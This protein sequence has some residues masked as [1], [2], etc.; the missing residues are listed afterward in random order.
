MTRFDNDK[1]PKLSLIKGGPEKPS[2][3][4]SSLENLSREQRELV[5][6]LLRKASINGVLTGVLAGD[7]IWDLRPLVL[8]NGTVGIIRFS[9]PGL[10]VEAN[11][12]DE[13]RLA[14]Q[15]LTDHRFFDAW[16]EIDG[17]IWVRRSFM[18]NTGNEEPLITAARSP[19]EAIQLLLQ[20]LYTMHAH[21]NIHGH[22]T[23]SN[24]GVEGAR[25]VLLDPALMSYSLSSK[26]QIQDAAP[27]IHRGY[28]PTFAS[29]LYG[30]GLVLKQILSQSA[31]SLD[32]R[33]CLESLLSP[34]PS[35]RPSLSW[36]EKSFIGEP[37]QE[38]VTPQQKDV[39]EEQTVSSSTLPRSVFSKPSVMLSLG[40]LI[41]II[42]GIVFFLG[43][44]FSINFSKPALP[45]DTYWSSNQLARMKEVAERAVSQNDK[46]AQ[47]VIIESLGKET[48]P[49]Y[50]LSPVLK[51]SFDP[52]W[53]TELSNKDRE[54]A[55]RIALAPLLPPALRQGTIPSSLHPGIVLG[56]VGTS[57]LTTHGEQFKNVATNDLGQ[58][59][60][61]IG[62]LFESLSKIGTHN[63]EELASRGAAHIVLGDI[64]EK[65][66]AAYLASEDGS[67]ELARTKLLIPF[68][69]D[70]ATAS[71]TV[72]LTLIASP[73]GAG[74]I[75][76]WFEQNPLD[77]W[78]KVSPL[79]KILVIV[80]ED[81]PE[82]LSVEQC[83][84]LFYFPLPDTHSKALSCVQK[85]ETLRMY[86]AALAKHA[87][88]MTRIQTVSLVSALKSPA[89]ASRSFIAKWFE[90]KPSVALVIDLL[91]AQSNKGVSDMLSLEAARYLTTQLDH[92]TLT[93]DQIRSL[94]VHPEPLVRA[95]GYLKLNV[96]IPGEKEILKS[97]SKIEP[98]ERMR[99][100]LERRL[101][102]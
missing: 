62:Y 13:F 102:Q 50:I 3:A 58:L 76:Q 70:N 67:V 81:L 101:S 8:H 77:I 55:F 32:Q 93:R 63:M 92:L 52:R 64:G 22:I 42:L 73:S 18:Q 98:D 46:E 2:K 11:R 12:F 83:V 95:L 87:S 74:K 53:E 25:M 45:Y 97:M 34:D 49:P 94:T 51:H 68:I 71:S 60:G 85:D 27:E 16:G 78:K 47:A 69:K 31:M 17:R 80:D 84:D 4:V 72:F 23:L 36:V 91:A 21:G 54:F 99:K 88:G 6:D 82:G 19:R 15:R 5:R 96:R 66:I 24:I 30:L 56:V 57:D 79:T 75:A 86:S 10:P 1:S 65:S 61:D 7:A 39:S 48:Q 26:D 59:P 40:A 35:R 14:V 41:P 90:S 37:Y 89:E 44:R 9:D 43:F 28:P 29:D 20:T 100:E 38:P 33:N